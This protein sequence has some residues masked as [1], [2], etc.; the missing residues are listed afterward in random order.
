MSKIYYT[1]AEALK[2]IDCEVLYNYT[3]WRSGHKFLRRGRAW[4]TC[5]SPYRNNQWLV[6][7]RQHTDVRVNGQILPYISKHSL[8]NPLRPFDRNL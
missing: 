3:E 5:L 8:T 7:R 1:D 6:V 4:I 2:L